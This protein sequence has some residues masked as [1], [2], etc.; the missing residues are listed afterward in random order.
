MSRLLPRCLTLGCCIILLVVVLLSLV[1][2]YAHPAMYGQV[3]EKSFW[4]MASSSGHLHW[5][6]YHLHHDDTTFSGIE[7]KENALA[8]NLRV[9]QQQEVIPIDQVPSHS[10]SPLFVNVDFPLIGRYFPQWSSM[11]IPSADA[12][13]EDPG[14]FAEQIQELAIPYWCPLV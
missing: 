1:R 12:G 14:Q 6:S 4:S 11:T 13:S 10:A 2:S 5:V 9:Q 7:V 3:S 8:C